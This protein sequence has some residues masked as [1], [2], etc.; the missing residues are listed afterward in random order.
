MRLHRPVCL[1][2]SRRGL[3]GKGILSENRALRAE[4]Y[5]GIRDFTGKGTETE[6]VRFSP[7]VCMCNYQSL[8]QSVEP[9]SQLS[10]LSQSLSESDE[11]EAYSD[12]AKSGT[13]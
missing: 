10:E 3:R 5:A 9:E 7:S 13:S 12:C 6:V 2:C 1:Y 11:E 8:L 4:L